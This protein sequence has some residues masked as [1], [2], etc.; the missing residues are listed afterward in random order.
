MKLNRII[1][2][3]LVLCIT[4]IT[5]ISC[6]NT[7]DGGEGGSGEQGGESGGSGESGG[8]QGG[9]SG[10]GSTEPVDFV[11][12]LK[13]D[14]NSPTAKAEVTVKQYIDGDTTHFYL[15]SGTI[16]G[17]NVVKARYLAVD[18][19]ESTGRVEPWGKA[20]A[21]F[22]K[23]KLK[24]AVSIMVE[25][26]TADWETDSNG[27]HLL[28]IWYK[29]SET[30]EYRNLNLELIQE[31]LAVGSGTASNKY[32][33]I[34][35]DALIQS[36]AQNLYVFSDEKD[37]N[38]HY[39]AAI[40]LTLKELRTN[41][42]SYE[43]AK[44]SFTG[45][46][47]YHYNNGCYI[48]EYDEVT[49]LYYGMY[50][51]YG[52]GFSGPGIEALSV[53]NEVRVAGV[54]GYYG[55]SGWQV[56]SPVYDVADSSNPDNIKILSKWNDPSYTPLDP[57]EFKTGS[58]EL[59]VGEEDEIKEFKYCELI[60]GTSVSLKAAK[61]TRVTTT[62]NDESSSK[63]ALTI[64]CEQNGASITIR[65]IVLY[66]EYGNLVTAS[67]FEGKTID[68]N[69]VVCY[70]DPDTMDEDEGFYQIQVLSYSDIAISSGN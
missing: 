17:S 65:T 32:G 36:K 44:V 7:G 37:P 8:E 19:P 3:L 2:L 68:V 4:L 30:A 42:A 38:F 60:A 16:D 23:N 66:D 47:S 15:K 50:L 39:G 58:L 59:P 55:M 20:A 14:M 52:N 54:V 41:V 64:T 31:G 51:Y 13:L 29:T 1:A 25:A 69:G 53:G 45:V 40:P 48:E 27:R 18:T 22:T 21:N 56:S 35:T 6:G 24:A 63:G 12:A 5:F 11:S 10:G 34:C 70:Y 9:S 61:V 49:D 43:G 57:L 26:D 46:V 33:S 67:E 62:T 28:W